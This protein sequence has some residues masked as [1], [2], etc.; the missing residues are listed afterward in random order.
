MLPG[1]AWV[2]ADVRS[3]FESARHDIVLDQLRKRVADER[4]LGLVGDLLTSVETTKGIG[5]GRGTNT[6]NLFGDVVLSVIDDQYPVLPILRSM[7]PYLFPPGKPAQKSGRLNT[8]HQNARNIRDKREIRDRDSRHLK[9][10]TSVTSDTPT[11]IS[12]TSVPSCRHGLVRLAVPIAGDN[13]HRGADDFCILVPGDR[14][15]AELVRGTVKQQLAAIGLSLSES[16]TLVGGRGDAFEFLG[17]RLQADDNGVHLTPSAD[18]LEDFRGE[19]DKVLKQL[20]RQNRDQP[21]VVI[22][23]MR[24]RLQSR[25]DYFERAGA[26]TTSM[27]QY[28]VDRL[29]QCKKEHGWHVLIRL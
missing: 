8:S 3:F 29:R 14:T 16:K 17:I 15:R 25:T 12:G 4:V 11:P 10:K 13:Y 9:A 20:V 23:T 2:R 26:D 5:I 27:R 22:S 19:I 18:H 1:K 21:R 6:A 28:V 24:R 7:D